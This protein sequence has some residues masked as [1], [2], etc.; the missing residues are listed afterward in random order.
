METHA[1]A[2]G[3]D[4]GLGPLGRRR[5]ARALLRRGRR[6][7]AL[8]HGALRPRR[9]RVRD[10][11][12]GRLRLADDP[13]RRR[14]LPRQ[15]D[16]RRALPGLC[17]RSRRRARR[18][19][20][21]GCHTSYDVNLRLRLTTPESAAERLQEV[22]GLLDAVLCSQHDA[23]ALL[24]LADPEALRDRLGVPLV[25]MSTTTESGR[26]R[27]AVGDTTEELERPGARMPST[28]SAAATRSPP[29]SCT[30]FC[31]AAC[32]TGSS[33]ATRCRC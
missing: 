16:H 2:H 20:A 26:G 32:A 24:G 7:A 18:G 6:P 12:P 5:P 4:T 33:S 9:L 23:E 1:R 21:A 28:R 13:R 17:T 10:A 25:V 19:A 29:A 27:I 15:R 22:A 14:G 11:R 30:G 31:T 8:E 3:V